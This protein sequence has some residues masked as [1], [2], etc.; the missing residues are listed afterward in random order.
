MLA[1]S[2]SPRATAALE[3][4]CRD[5]T[6]PD[7]VTIDMRGGYALGPIGPGRGRVLVAIEREPSPPFDMTELNN[8]LA[9]A[10]GAAMGVIL[11]VAILLGL[12][13]FRVIVSRLHRLRACL[14]AVGEG[15]LSCRMDNPGSDE[16]GDLGRSFN[17]MAERLQNV[18]SKLEQVDESRRQFLADISHELR[19]PLTSI[20]AN[21]ESV[22]EN[23]DGE[24]GRRVLGVQ[25]C[26]QE[27]TRSLEEVE[28]VAS[29]VEDLLELGRMES[30]RFHL[31]RDDCVLQ[32]LAIDALARLAR[33]IENRRIQIAKHLSP[34]P[35]RRTVDARRMRQVLTN[36]LSNAIR[37]VD[38]GGVIEVTVEERDGKAVIE[39]ADNG[40][41]IA[42]EQLPRI[43]ERFEAGSRGGT[44]LG[45]SIVRRLVEAH[46]GNVEL[47]PRPERGIVAVVQL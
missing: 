4:L 28:H 29:L 16:I 19:T 40:P 47:R 7:P 32:V 43:F 11:L 10:F 5:T 38:E 12:L 22:V 39:I 13:V 34:E 26:R 31:E 35:V 15:D 20:R 3:I 14:G 9:K 37:S 44:G 46:G 25:D 36:L 1:G 45:L 33:S 30:P 23:R 41:G 2:P 8:Q 42:T 24:T 21:L 17:G 27:V 18:V 6:R